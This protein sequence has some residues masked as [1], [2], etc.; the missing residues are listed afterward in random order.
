[1]LLSFPFSLFFCRILFPSPV[2]K[3][4]GFTFPT[5]HVGK[6]EGSITH[7]CPYDPRACSAGDA[8]AAHFIRSPFFLA[9]SH[10]LSLSFSLS[11][12]LSLLA[13]S[14]TFSFSHNLSVLPSFS[15]FLS[16]SPLPPLSFSFYHYLYIDNYYTCICINVHLHC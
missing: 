8:M 16:L 11:L 3:E 4:A 7:N 14:F 6:T 9:F 15:L 1:L 10:S 5:L 12:S 2:L 13:L